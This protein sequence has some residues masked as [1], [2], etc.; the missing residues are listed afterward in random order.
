MQTV[1]RLLLTENKANQPEKKD[2]PGMIQYLIWFWNFLVLFVYHE[3]GLDVNFWSIVLF[4]LLW[5]CFWGSGETAKTLEEQMQ[6]HPG[7]LFWTIWAG[8]GQTFPR[9]VWGQRKKRPRCNPIPSTTGWG[10]VEEREFWPGKTRVLLPQSVCETDLLWGFV[11]RF[12]PSCGQDRGHRSSIWTA[13]SYW[14]YTF[15]IIYRCI[16]HGSLQQCSGTVAEQAP[17]LVNIPK[18]WYIAYLILLG[19]YRGGIVFLH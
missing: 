16:L 4:F 1:L 5:P 12:I 15:E 7:K 19:K 8:W 17:W 18:H 2:Q 11:G 6:V 10:E 14:I 3:F 13:T 9:H